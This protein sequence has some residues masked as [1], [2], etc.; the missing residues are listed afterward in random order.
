MPPR[1][2]ACSF[3][4]TSRE[5]LIPFCPVLTCRSSKSRVNLAP[6]SFPLKMT[7]KAF[8]VSSKAF[9]VEASARRSANSLDKRAN[10]SLCDSLSSF[11]CIVGCVPAPEEI[12]APSSQVCGV[13]GLSKAPDNEDLCCIT[14]R[15]KY[16]SVS[17]SIVAEA[18]AHA[19]LAKQRLYSAY[20]ASFSANSF[21]ETS[22]V[23][24]RVLNIQ[25]VLRIQSSLE[26]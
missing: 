25:K 2:V 12:P 21:Q 1:S 17:K 9:A 11:I 22:T 24:F 23:S 5:E 7:C 10:V 15:S 20:C 13:P 18:N 14:C 3:A 4:D 19:I 16:D 26:M 6:S 8:A